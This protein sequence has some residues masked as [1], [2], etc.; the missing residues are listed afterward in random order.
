MPRLGESCGANSHRQLVSELSVQSADATQ[1]P[2]GDRQFGPIAIQGRKRDAGGEG[3][4]PEGD[5]QFGR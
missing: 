2:S 3:I 1:A 4:T 5:P